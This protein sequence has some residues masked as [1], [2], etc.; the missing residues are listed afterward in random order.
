MREEADVTRESERSQLFKIAEYI[1]ASASVLGMVASTLTQQ[2]GYFAAPLSVTLLLNLLNR[3]RFEQQT[4]QQMVGVMT[5]VNQRLTQLDHTVSELPQSLTTNLSQQVQPLGEQLEAL[6]QQQTD[7]MGTVRHFQEQLARLAQRV[8]DEIQVVREAIP[9]SVEATNLA[10]VQ[11]IAAALT[12]LQT[13]V[14]ALDQQFRQLAPSTPSLEPLTEVLHQQI[15]RLSDQI[16]AIQQAQAESQATAA[17]LENQ[18]AQFIPSLTNELQSIWQQLDTP[19]AVAGTELPAIEQMVAQLQTR[20]ADLEQVDR[21]AGVDLQGIE[22]MVAQLQTRLADLERVDRTPLSESLPQPAPSV[23]ASVERETP[24]D[25]EGAIVPV[26]PAEP[27]SALEEV[28]PNVPVEIVNDELAGWLPDSLLDSIPMTEAALDLPT[29]PSEPLPSVPVPMPELMASSSEALSL[30]LGIDFGTH[31]T[32]VCFHDSIRNGSEVIVFAE[33]PADPDAALLS[34]QIGIRPDGTLLAGTTIAEWAEAEFQLT[35]VVD[36]IKLH[37]ARL[38]CP[39]L[40]EEWPLNAIAELDTAETVE[41]LC[42]YYLSQVISRAQAWIYR[43]KPALVEHQTVRW[44]VNLG[45]P[46]T[47]YTSGAR[48]RLEMV[49]SLAWMLSQQP[50]VAGT[51]IQALSDQLTPLRLQ[52]ATESTPCHVVPDMAAEVGVLLEG[53]ER[54]SGFCVCFHVEDRHLE[55]ALLR[56]GWE[57]EQPY[58]DVYSAKLAPLGVRSV[59]QQLAAELGVL[60]EDIRYTIEGNSLRYSEQIQ[61]SQTR[62][63]VQQLVGYVVG[64]GITTARDQGVVVDPAAAE[65]TI[66]IAGEGGQTRFY[67]QA[68][69]STYQDFGHEQAG[70]PPYRLL[71]LPIP[72]NAELNGLLQSQFYRFA[73]AYGLALPLTQQPTIRPRSRVGD[74]G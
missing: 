32:R 65:L 15:T 7:S 33:D 25:A 61:A 21:T 16:A 5:Q 36:C 12:H 57:A 27:E 24:S 69:L 74:V 10:E 18:F 44:S 37:L 64:Q 30:T 8:S 38:D 28:I 46:L 39:Q 51:T 55:G 59:S 62:K 11:A 43:H 53:A 66:V 47:L 17:Q 6:E 60:E 2:V 73:I 56:Y 3:Q 13:Q 50:P 20:L 41:H 70:I 31:T 45:I 1:T 49:L 40:L 35:T 54:Q 42:T 52:L 19:T 58:L 4:Q 26:A 67:T 48:Q 34:T 14:E 68:V 71:P 9:A 22:Q 29:I 23:T 63:Q 72:A